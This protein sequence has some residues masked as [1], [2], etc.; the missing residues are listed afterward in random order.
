MKIFDCFTYCGEDLLLEIRL[1]TLHSDVDYFVI[2]E[3][4]KFHSG[5]GR[6][7][8][9]NIEKFKKFKSKIRYFFID[10]PPLHDG[11][12][13]KYENFQRNQLKLGIYDAVDN[14][15]IMVS[16][17]D[18]IPNLNNKDFHNYDSCIFLQ[19]FYYFKFNNLCYEGLKWKNKWPGTKSIK[20]K[21]FKTAQNLRELRVKNIPK[22]RIDQRV[23]RLIKYEGGWHFSYLMTPEQ[24]SEKIQN[25]A[26]KEYYSFSNLK[27]IEKMIKEKK[28]IF[29][30]NDL[31][32]KTVSID[33]T[34]P[35]YIKNNI[36]V[37][38][39]WID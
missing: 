30:R 21:Y 29:S 38:Q 11:D 9:F 14:D 18:E 3:M 31:K 35:D 8:K 33:D 7:Q 23:N 19:N 32:F 39:K 2:C 26:H 10:N 37:Y 17:L 27:H 6:E 28:D 24:I 13:W 20:F 4:S 1:N 25:F 34:Y 12:N 22:W 16:D 5:K 36:K 15:I